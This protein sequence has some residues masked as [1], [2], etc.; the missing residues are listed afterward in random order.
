MT[1]GR[2]TNALKIN[3][4][5]IPKQEVALKYLLDNK[6]TAIWYWGAAWWGKSYLG[7]FRIWMM[8]MQ[9]PWT[10]WFIGRKELT[11][12]MKTTMQSYW[13]MKRDY[14]IPDYAMG[15]I[16]WKNNII[17][18]Q[19]GSQVYL[20]DLAYKPAD[21]MYARLWSMEFTWGFVDESAEIADSALTILRTR[22]WRQL[23]DEYK[24][25]PKILETFNP[26]K[27]HVYSDY[28]KLWKENA[29]PEWKVFIPSLATDNPHLTADYIAQLERSDEITRQRLLYGNFD[30][31]DTES[32]L[33]RT[34]EVMDMFTNIVDKTWTNYLSVDVARQWKD[35]T[36]IVVWDWLVAIRCGK[37][38][39]ATT[40]VVAQRIK[41][42]EYQYSVHRHN[43]VVDTDWLWV[44]VA[45]QVRGCYQFHNASR[46]IETESSWNFWNLKTQCY[47]K[48]Q[49]LAEKR[50]IRLE[51]DWADRE[52][53]VL[54]LENILVKN[55]DK[56]GKRLL[57]SKE[58]MKKRLWNKSPDIADAIM[59]RMVYS[60]EWTEEIRTYKAVF[61]DYN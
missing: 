54:E 17:K 15:K 10:R 59:M 39:W 24:L 29:L 22:V 58:D 43:I 45:D 44:W 32:K 40:D 53:L 9:Y 50:K 6:T 37:L 60:L 18:Y 28:Y 3:F 57:E 34:D 55:L 16:D 56:D 11:N 19:N 12:L 49:E 38:Q 14:N 33:F 47:Y 5:P 27:W 48:L 26:D 46:P 13:D 2:M 21:P 41:D 20:L 4:K 35:S 8:A 31:D 25:K 61:D 42:L 52:D 1:K 51:L 36:R 23:N 30:Y 7:V